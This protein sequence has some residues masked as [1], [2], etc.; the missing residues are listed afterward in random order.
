[1]VEKPDPFVLV[2]EIRN[3]INCVELDPNPYQFMQIRLHLNHLTNT[4]KVYA[5]SSGEEKI[6]MT[7][8]RHSDN[9]RRN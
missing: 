7:Q 1:M 3:A 6:Q 5:Q 9:D 8:L 4:I 2:E